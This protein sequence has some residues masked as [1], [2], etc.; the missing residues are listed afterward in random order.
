MGELKPPFQFSFT[1]D[2]EPDDLWANRP[3]LTFEHFRRLPEFHRKMRAA[4]AKP[5]YLTTSE[6]AQDPGARAVLRQFLDEGGCE[7]G[8]HFH[9]WTR[10]WPFPV[11]DLSWRGSRLHAM[12]HQLGQGVEEAMLDYTCGELASAFGVRPAS[13]RGG[14]WSLSRDTIT[15]LRNCGIEVDSTV[16]PGIV[17]KDQRHTLLDG[18]DFSRSS[19]FPSSLSRAMGGGDD[20]QGPLEIPV[21]SA[22]FPEWGEHAGDVVRKQ[23]KRVGDHTPIRAGHRLL[24]PTRC[25]VEDMTAVMKSLKKAGVPVWVL[26]IHSSEISPCNPLPNE[27]EVQKFVDRCER[28]VQ[29]ALELG[30]VSS[31]LTEAAAGLRGS[32]A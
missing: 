17:W 26:M 21:G 23:L 16:T 19:R 15:S 14:R 32:F 9:S 12:A 31:T 28:I 5:V 1:L 13:Y 30:A 2:T 29:V 11:P 22:W 24:R 8:A 18:P 25:S 4:G 10:E 20:R 6:V 7:I 3:E 27:E